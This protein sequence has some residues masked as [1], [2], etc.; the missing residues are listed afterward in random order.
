MWPVNINKQTHH[1]LGIDLALQFEKWTLSASFFHYTHH[2]F[3]LY[4]QPLLVCPKVQN[5]RLWVSR[6]S[7]STRNISLKTSGECG[8]Y[9]LVALRLR[10][11][12]PRRILVYLKVMLINLTQPACGSEAMK[13]QMGLW[14]LMWCKLCSQPS[15]PSIEKHIIHLLYPHS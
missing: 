9:M 3:L 11:Q 15:P 10:Q 2:Q 8:L 4:A 12:E 5:Q 7:N 1:A 13:S 14:P 6:H